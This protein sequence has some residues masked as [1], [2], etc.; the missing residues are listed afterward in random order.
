[1]PTTL[2]DIL[3]VEKTA[4]QPEIKRAYRSTARKAHPDLGGSQ[5]EMAELNR[6]WECLGNPVR[7]LIYDETGRDA[8][9]NSIDEEAR[10]IIANTFAQLLDIDK[11]SDILSRTVQLISA[12]RD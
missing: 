5:A 7:R 2:Y 11:M 6:A 1:M 8:P 10:S 3:G 9:V 4:T 12:M